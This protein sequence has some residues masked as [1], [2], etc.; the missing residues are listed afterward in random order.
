MSGSVEMTEP[1]EAIPSFRV[2]GVRMHPLQIPEI[3]RIIDGW[4]RKRDSVHYVCQ[5]GMHGASEVVKR[6]HLREILNR[7]D[8]NNMDGMPM[9][10]LARLHGFEFAQ[11]RATGTELMGELLATG[12]KYKHFFYG[13]RFSRELAEQCVKKYGTRE[14]CYIARQSARQKVTCSWFAG[15]AIQVIPNRCHSCRK[16]RLL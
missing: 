3:L 8:L 4:I 9:K 6:P 5:T 15:V 14:R 7:A 13:N 10:W 1:R 16:T 12:Q 11:R 2:L